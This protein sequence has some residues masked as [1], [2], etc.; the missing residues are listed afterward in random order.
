MGMKNAGLVFGVE[1]R[2]R[3]LIGPR[4]P[5]ELRDDKRSSRMHAAG[6]FIGSHCPCADHGRLMPRTWPRALSR[7]SR[8]GYTFVRES[9]EI[10]RIDSQFL[11]KEVVEKAFS[12]FQRPG[13]DGPENEF[14]EA[15]N[16]YREGRFKDAIVD[17]LKA[18]ESTIKTICDRRI[19]AYSPNATAKDLIAVIFDHKLVASNQQ[20]FFSALRALLECGLPTVRNKTSGHGQGADVVEVPQHVAGYALHLAAS[21]I[22]L[23]A[24]A[25]KAKP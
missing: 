20:S 12:L 19:W 13:F 24:E 4:R 14:Q 3:N 8:F 16:K 15:H 5:I 9:G 18:F 6:D 22:V 17:A 1:P 21:T 2:Q 25:D 23:L 11:H 7:S 10:I